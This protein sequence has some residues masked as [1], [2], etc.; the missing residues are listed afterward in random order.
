VQELIR[1]ERAA[2]IL[3]ISPWTVRKMITFNKLRS[4]KIGRRRLLEAP[5]LQRLIDEGCSSEPANRRP[6]S[7]R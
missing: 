7:G 1:I 4:V 2:E 3:G 6:V 5:E